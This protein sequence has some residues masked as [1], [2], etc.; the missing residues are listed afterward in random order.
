MYS[1]NYNGSIFPLSVTNAP[2]KI[3]YLAQRIISKFGKFVIDRRAMVMY[4]RNLRYGW[5]ENIM[6]PAIYKLNLVVYDKLNSSNISY[7]RQIAKTSELT[8]REIEDRFR[9]G[10]ICFLVT[11]ENGILAHFIWVCFKKR[12]IE[13]VDHLLKLKEDEASVYNG[14]TFEEYRGFSIYPWVLVNIQK[15]LKTK[16][17]QNVYADININNSASIKGVKKAGFELIGDIKFVSVFR[18]IKFKKIIEN[19]KYEN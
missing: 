19:K 10:D 13:Y 4:K 8:Q 18:V 17:I 9:N 6:P 16:G 1:K 7:M 12:Y 11:D 3:V 5:S 15:F 14:Y 2:R